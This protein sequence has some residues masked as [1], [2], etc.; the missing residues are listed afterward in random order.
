[1]PQANRREEDRVEKQQK[2]ELVVR[3]EGPRHQ[4]AL[5]PDEVQFRSMLAAAKGAIALR[6]LRKLVAAWL[7]IAKQCDGATEEVL[8]LASY[9]LEVEWSLGVEVAQTVDRGD[10]GSKS[11]DATSKRGGA[12]QRLPKGVDKHQSHRYQAL[13]AIPAEVFTAYIAEAK[14]APKQATSFGAHRFARKVDP[15]LKAKRKARAGKH[16]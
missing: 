11:L 15:E 4:L 9:R 6:D 14:P 16:R 8:S 10:F 5:V 12:S 7:A 2:E 13:A 1:M 3:Q